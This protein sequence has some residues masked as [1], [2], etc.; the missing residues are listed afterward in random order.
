MHISKV[1]FEKIY[2]TS[3]YINE[4]VGI[5]VVLNQ[6]ESANEALDIARELSDE[7]QKEKHPELYKGN[8]T[9]LTAEEAALIKDMSLVTNMEM[10][11]P[12]KNKL[13]TPNLRAAYMENLKR[14]TIK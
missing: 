14:L 3:S 7:W 11:T 13:N 10:L 8:K 4:R 6:G 5:E 2:P 9:E 1:Y 12:F